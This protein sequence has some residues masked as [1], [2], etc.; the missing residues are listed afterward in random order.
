MN[1]TCANPH[2][3]ELDMYEC[4]CSEAQYKKLTPL[5]FNVNNKLFNLPVNAWMSYTPP[6][7]K[8]ANDDDDD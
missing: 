6:K 4:A 7:P 8:K 5:Q 3:Q 2:G 1:M